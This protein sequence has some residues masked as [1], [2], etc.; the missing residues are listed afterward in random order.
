MVS[1]TK[2]FVAKVAIGIEGCALLSIEETLNANSAFKCRD[3]SPNLV[4]EDIQNSSVY[5]WF[6]FNI[7]NKPKKPGVY[8]LRGTARFTDDSADYTTTFDEQPLL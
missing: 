5:E 3:M 7:K 2:N 1:I 6:E 8:V 4:L